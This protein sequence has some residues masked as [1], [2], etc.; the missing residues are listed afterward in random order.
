LWLYIR[1]GNDDLHR[2]HI[3]SG[4]AKIVED[5]LSQCS[6]AASILTF[7][8]E[9]IRKAL[10]L[11]ARN[12]AS[13]RTQIA[14]LRNRVRFLK[15]EFV[16]L[17]GGVSK[18]QWC[19]TVRVQKRPKSRASNAMQTKYGGWRSF[20]EARAFARSLPVRT[21]IEWQDWSK[22]SVR[23]IDIP[24]NPNRVYRENGWIDWA[25]W[26]SKFKMTT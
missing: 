18:R 15:G 26:L 24:S 13:T 25:D 10:G 22:T 4:Q 11:S 23:P 2:F 8:Y 1:C 9:S 7:T 5:A 21:A 19:T 17:I 6:G 16:G 12:D 20:K 3:S 14:R